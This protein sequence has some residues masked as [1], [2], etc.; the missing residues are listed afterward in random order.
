MPALA[1]AP[2]EP[3]TTVV[4]ATLNARPTV[5]DCVDSVLAAG[6]PVGEV[7]I[8]DRGSTDGTLEIARRFGPPVRVL[9]RRGVAEGAAVEAGLAEAGTSVVAV[10]PSRSVVAVG[11]LRAGEVPLRPVGT[12]AFG[13]AAAV[14]VGRDVPTITVTGATGPAPA[15]PSW[16]FVA[17]TAA[18]LAEDAFR[19][20]A[21]ARG[22]L[23][24]ASVALAVFGRGRLRVAVPVGHA[25][26]TAA[27]AVRAADDPGVAPHRAFLAGEIRDWAGGAGWWAARRMR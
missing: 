15:L 13:R 19:R 24:G 16:Y 23:V 20:P 4:I 10:V 1:S 7:L 17:G 6:T 9:E 5:R 11:A 3:L 21:P 25:L 14:M 26:V 22:A 8:V 27:R 18:G 12:T 2:P